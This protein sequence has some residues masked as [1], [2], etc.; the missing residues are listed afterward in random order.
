M[1]FSSPPVTTGRSIIGMLGMSVVTS[2]SAMMPFRM[3]NDASVVKM[4][5]SMVSASLNK[6]D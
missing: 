3:L 6:A 1:R 2:D 4:R 5:G